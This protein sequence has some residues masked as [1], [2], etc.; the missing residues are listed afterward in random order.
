[1]RIRLKKGIQ[2]KIIL[3]VKNKRDLTWRE[4]SVILNVNEKYL[5]WELFNEKR[6]LS[7]E[8]YNKLC[9]LLKK[10]F[11]KYILNKLNN[12]WG[13]SLGGRNSIKE[14]KIVLEEKS[15]ELAEFIGIMI[16]DGNI[17]E[18]DKG[19]YYIN[20]SG[21]L[22]KDKDYLINY[23]NP[24][25]KKLFKREMNIKINQKNKSI[26]LYIGDK[27][28]VFTLKNFG[29]KS[30]NKKKNNIKIPRWIFED[31]E[32]LRCCIRGLIDTDG[33]VC[34]ITGRD[35]N[36]IWFSS[37]IEN[38]RTDFNKAMKKLG[39]K[40]SKWSIKEGRTPDIYIGSKKEIKRYIETISFKNRRN[41]D[42]L[43]APL[44]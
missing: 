38:I 41:L 25:F 16:G 42:K 12:N 22:E 15:K 20:I 28:I 19:Y 24:L 5:K 14:E 29:L 40:T 36:Y 18:N 39:F 23:V 27:N 11:N 43:N 21:N 4:L 10:N 26:Y 9:N 8:I 37:G 2:K 35:Y 31:K 32:Y 33:C 6:T 30:G 3:K 13:R 34:P 17:W 7:E 44:V 1:M